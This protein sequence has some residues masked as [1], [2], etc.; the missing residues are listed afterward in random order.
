MALRPP[1][2]AIF[3]FLDTAGDGTGTKNAIGDYST[4]DEFFFSYPKD[5]EIERMVIHISDT[6]MTQDQ[7]GDLTALSTGYSVSVIDSAGATV[8][9]LTDGVPIKKNADFGRYCYDVNHQSWGTT[10]TN[11]FV[12]ARWTFSKAGHPLYL[13]AGSKLSITFSDNLTGLIE[14]YFMI[15]GYEAH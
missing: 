9:D 1:S 12:Q 4:P 5:V 13:A 2:E 7:Y 11:E 14:H 6:A 8:L 15:Q 3:R 10:P